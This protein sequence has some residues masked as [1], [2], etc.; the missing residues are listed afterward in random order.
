MNLDLR[1]QC[2]RI[3]NLLTER[4]L[5]VTMCLGTNRK[6]WVRITE[7]DYSVYR[8]SRRRTDAIVNEL[9]ESKNFED[10]E[11]SFSIFSFEEEEEEE[12]E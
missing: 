1:I 9:L 7:Q 11:N 2:E 6:L 3:E 8:N 10:F 4:D 12:Y 5:V